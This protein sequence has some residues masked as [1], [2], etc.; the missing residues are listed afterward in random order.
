MYCTLYPSKLVFR[1]ILAELSDQQI[2]FNRSFCEWKDF[3]YCS[4]QV[5]SDI[6]IGIA[7]SEIMKV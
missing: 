3:Y 1:V 5:I 2:D 6:N 7:C 4:S